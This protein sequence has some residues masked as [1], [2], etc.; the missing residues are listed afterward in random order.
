MSITPYLRRFCFLVCLGSVSLLAQTPDLVLTNGCLAPEH[1]AMSGQTLDIG[2]LIYRPAT[3][4]F[5]TLWVTNRGDG[6]IRLTGAQM[7]VVSGEVATGRVAQPSVGL[8][9]P[10]KSLPLTLAFEVDELGDYSASVAVTHANPDMYPLTVTLSYRVEPSNIPYYG[11][12]PRSY[13]PLVA[14]GEVLFIRPDVI[15]R[16]G[17][18]PSRVDTWHWYK[19]G[20]L[21]PTQRGPVL[22]V[23]EAKASDAGSYH[24]VAIWSGLKVE[25]TRVSIGVY[26]RQQ[27]PLLLEIGK[28]L[29]LT[30]RVWG[31]KTEVRWDPS[32]PESL[33]FRGTATAT[34]SVADHSALRGYL[35]VVA[36]ATIYDPELGVSELICVERPIEQ[37][38]QKV[39]SILDSTLPSVMVKGVERDLSGYALGAYS[40]SDEP[41]TFTAQGLPPGL[42][43]R[44]EDNVIWGAPT[45]VG[46]YKV[47]ISASNSHGK[48]KPFFWV[49]EIVETEVGD[50]GA[51]G[52]FLGV[53]A[54]MPNFGI[55]RRNGMVELEL[56]PG[57]AFTGQLRIG[58]QPRRFF[59]SLA[60][61]DISGTEREITLELKPLAGNAR[62]LLTLQQ[63]KLT[64][65][66]QWSTLDV[67]LTVVDTDGLETSYRTT[68]E[69]KLTP[70][71][72]DRL[73]LK[74]KYNIEL[75]R[76]DDEPSF[77]SG[78]G[79]GSV[80]FTSAAR[81]HIVGTLADGSGFT[82]SSALVRRG[83]E[84]TLTDPQMLVAFSDP[85]AGSLL[86]SLVIR[87]ISGLGGPCL[88][89]GE[90]RWSR[91]ADEKSRFAP[92][93][94]DEVLLRANGL[95]YM[96]PA[97]GLL[98]LNT[99]KG[100][101]NAVMRCYNGGLVDRMFYPDASFAT[102]FTLTD[103]HR[104]FFSND[105]ENLKAVKLDIFAPTGFF[106]GQFIHITPLTDDGVTVNV[107]RKVSFRGMM[108]GRSH[109][110]GFFLFPGLPD[111]STVPP[112][113]LTNSLIHS[114]RVTLTQ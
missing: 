76:I 66:A 21:L 22:F 86:G 72:D 58:N 68:M 101:D 108:M 54:V 73:S 64:W 106:T 51:G 13:Q 36:R 111:A 114:G 47:R 44:E 84:W 43:L 45:Q 57:G 79:F 61:D 87:S 63:R 19:N 112:T 29:S 35:Q 2:N 27:S 26:E 69:R 50:F 38:L 85:K 92:E 6:A 82:A 94:L 104:A 14:L 78:A 20:K 31:P 100:K 46:L 81:G 10:G 98:L 33:L 37:P 99:F 49:V 60:K 56:T 17:L 71:A 28:P 95:P 9:A 97:A 48:A 18:E 90:L 30:A 7:Q 109:G 42:Q 91:P 102:A 103:K 52:T 12:R 96:R 70:T 110:S 8:L 41:I 40:D 3:E 24:L 25:T 62:T 55:V 32:M 75:S 16:N 93:G 23:P 105:L 107:Q 15:T 11:T 39:P 53:S 74:E 65:A 5:V 59:G 89:E 88:I 1:V 4:S 80:T 67:T 77:P 34:L 113:T 83:L